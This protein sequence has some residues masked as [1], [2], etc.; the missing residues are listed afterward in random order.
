[1]IS[2]KFVLK[3]INECK[4][5]T[6]FSRFC[7]VLIIST[8]NYNIHFE[9]D[10]FYLFVFLIFTN[11]FITTDIYSQLT[12]TF[13][14][15]LVYKKTNKSQTGVALFKGVN[16]SFICT[17]FSLWMTGYRQKQLCSIAINQL[18]DKYIYSHYF[19]ILHDIFLRSDLHLPV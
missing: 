5:L 6:I 10:H 14:K 8:N 18:E 15:Q 17:S 19:T 1:M 16:F 11:S 4:Y 3:D 2:K 12:K 7:E 9:L 13:H